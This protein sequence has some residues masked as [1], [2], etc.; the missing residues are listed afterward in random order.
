[1]ANLDGK[2][3]SKAATLRKPNPARVAAGKRNRKKRIGLTDAGREALRQ[4]ALLHKPWQ[5]ST[6]PRTASGKARVAMN[7]R[8]HQIGPISLRKL[9]AD[10]AELRDLVVEMSA[11]RRES[12]RTR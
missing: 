7:G 10:L 5:H 4:T 2:L 9:R 1:M 6:G 8:S 12:S 3:L 11:L